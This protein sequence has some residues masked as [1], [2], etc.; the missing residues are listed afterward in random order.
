MLGGKRIHST[1]MSQQD[2]TSLVSQSVDVART[3]SFEMSSA[4]GASAGV[5]AGLVKAAANLATKFGGPKGAAIGSVVNVALEDV[6][7]DKQLF[8]VSASK[9]SDYSIGQFASSLEQAEAAEKISEKKL[10]NQEVTIG[11]EPSA[12]WRQWAAT[13]KEKP[14]PIR[15]E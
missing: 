4:V 2:Y 11:G 3:M 1:S 9:K 12:D 14:M 5:K 10:T 15:Y 7:N 8:G 13:V 6:N